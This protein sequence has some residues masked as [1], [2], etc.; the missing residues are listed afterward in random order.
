[1]FFIFMKGVVVLTFAVVLIWIAYIAWM[2]NRNR[3]LISIGDS[4]VAGKEIEDIA[5][6][7]AGG[8]T[9]SKRKNLFYWPIQRM[10]ANYGCI[11][12]TYRTLNE[13][14]RKK[15]PV[16]DTAEWLLDNFYIIEEQVKVIRRDSDKKYYRKMP[17]LKSGPYKGFPRIF[18]I[19]MDLA[20]FTDGQVDD[21][22]LAGYL[23]A[24]QTR[25]PLYNREISALATFIQLALLEKVRNLCINIQNTLMKWQ[26]GDRII[27]NWLKSEKKDGDKSV[28]RHVGFK[29]AGE[30]DLRFLEHLFSRLRRSKRDYS[31]IQ[32]QIEEQLA[33]FGANLE[34]IILAEHSAQSKDTISM[35]NCITSLRYLSSMDWTA[36]L[37]ATSFVDEILRQDPDRTY[38]NMDAQTRGYYRSCVEKIASAYGVSEYQIAMEAVTL[39]KEARLLSGQKDGDNEIARTWHIGYY[40][41]GKGLKLLCERQHKAGRKTG[42]KCFHSGT[43][44]PGFVYFG[45]IA[46]LSLALIGIPVW[47]CVIAS[48]HQV[49]LAMLAGLGVLLPSVEI[50]VSA[51]NFIVCKCTKPAIFPKMDFKRGIPDD[52]RTFVVVPTLLSNENV[53]DHIK[54]L[55][56]QYLRNREKNLLFAVIGAFRDSES[57]LSSRDSGIVE[58]A[59]D[60]V[61]E[62][63]RKYAKQG[64]DIFYFFHRKSQFNRSNNNW[65]GWE[66]KRGALLEFND[67]LLG[68][69]D[70]SFIASSCSDPRL[71]NI[72]YVI[73]LDSDTI[74]PFGMAKK[75][76]KRWRIH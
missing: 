18:A 46:L 7:N 29:S 17:L 70:T 25:C 66:R 20:T 56:G 50:A 55:E 35:G 9:V 65:F 64:S 30:I 49:L 32:R 10:H 71:L 40:L 27:D 48:P 1:M 36:L 53:Q 5:L 59:M 19:A 68:S 28:K 67:L 13:H 73:T 24:Y 38:P 43:R 3:R 8:H 47:Y 42:R 57:E 52:M 22:V 4:I 69:T 15:Q 12:T 61:F 45:G 21:A 63:N 54:N 75:W 2:R 26:N 58:C 76:W 39:S 74:L 41:L 16:P 6:E 23:N 33:K 31:G 62:L 14:I 51:V 37:E 60:A 72:R 34:Q 11:L 44:H